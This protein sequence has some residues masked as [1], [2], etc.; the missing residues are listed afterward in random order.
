MLVRAVA[1]WRILR[2]FTLTPPN[3]FLLRHL[4]F[5]RLQA[6]ALV[7]AI[8]KRRMTRPTT[9]TPPVS[10]RLNFDR[11]GLEI[12]NNRECGHEGSWVQRTSYCEKETGNADRCTC[13]ATIAWVFLLGMAAVAGFRSSLGYL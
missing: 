5:Y 8:T 1:Q 7:R 4:V 13:V 11:H 12:T 10:P 2:M 6:S 3:S 9:G